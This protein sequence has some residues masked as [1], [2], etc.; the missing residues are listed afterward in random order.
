MLVFK[1]SNALIA[2]SD[3]SYFFMRSFLKQSGVVLDQPPVPAGH[4]QEPPHL[5]AMYPLYFGVVSSDASSTN[6]VS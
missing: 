6:H 4:A 1:R 2:S 5:F 3:N